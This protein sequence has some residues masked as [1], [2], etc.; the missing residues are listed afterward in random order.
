VFKTKDHLLH[1]EQLEH[2]PEAFK[3]LQRGIS[4]PKGHAFRKYDITKS[5][6]GLLLLSTRIRDYQDASRPRK[7]IPLLLKSSLTK[8]LLLSLHHQHLHQGTNTLLAIIGNTYHIP[9]IKNH[10]KG[11]SK[12]CP[13]CKR[14][15]DR[16]AHQHMGLLPTTRTTL[17]PPFHISGVDFA[18]PFVT[19]RG[20]TR[21]PT[22]IKAYACIFICFTTK[23]VH[24]ELCL[25]LS[26]EEFMAALRR[27]CAKREAPREIHS[28]NGTNFVGAANEFKRIQHLIQTSKD[29]ISHHATKNNII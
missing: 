5:S 4:L 22:M 19:R 21:K 8:R 20:H 28:D 16:S 23:A 25:D 26:T 17:N 12:R 2:F 13:Q 9:G 24:I 3:A 1:I 11:L 10:L 6:K 18:G 7:L 27:F 14:A 15:Y 29:T